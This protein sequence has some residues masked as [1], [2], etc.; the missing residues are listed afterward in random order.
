MTSETRPFRSD[1][2]FTCVNCLK[3]VT[4]L[5]KGSDHSLRLIICQPTCENPVDPLLELD[6][7]LIYLRLLCVDKA[8]IRH[9]V[10]NFSARQKFNTVDMGRVQTRMRL[11][12]MGCQAYL[13]LRY[14]QL[15]DN[16]ILFHEL[17]HDCNQALG[18]L[19]VAAATPEFCAYTIPGLVCGLAQAVQ[20]ALVSY[21]TFMSATQG[22]NVGMMA[23]V[24]SLWTPLLALTALHQGH[25]GAD[26]W[27]IAPFELAAVMD[28]VYTIA[29]YQVRLE[30]GPKCLQTCCLRVCLLIL[31]F[32]RKATVFR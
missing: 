7:I 20:H 5:W 25:R 26:N 21:S 31:A 28:L 32:V 27:P 10:F 2:G 3:R 1:A 23:L 8:T 12:L 19:E 13:L 9:A 17:R 6:G 29:C 16:G 14:I 24:S 11:L 18:K 4:A 15:S 30:R 22:V